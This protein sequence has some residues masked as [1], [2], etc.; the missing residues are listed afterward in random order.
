MWEFIPGRGSL[1]VPADAAILHHYRVNLHKN[2][3]S[4]YYYLLNKNKLK[5]IYF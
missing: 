5:E 1:N 2:N 3:V 4:L